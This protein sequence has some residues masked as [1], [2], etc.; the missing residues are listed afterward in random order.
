MALMYLCLALSVF[1]TV[2]YVGWEQ[3]KYGAESAENLASLVK[4]AIVAKDS[5]S[6]IQL[7]WHEQDATYE[8]DTVLRDWNILEESSMRL[9]IHPDANY[10]G[11]IIFN[12]NPNTSLSI[13]NQE[14]YGWHIVSGCPRNV[15]IRPSPTCSHPKY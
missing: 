2:I 1:V 4:V 15:S 8:F 7:T 3:Q 6:L 10:Q 12:E 9:L 14:R 13:R 5:R 11:T